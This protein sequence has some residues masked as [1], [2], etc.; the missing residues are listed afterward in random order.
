MARVPTVRAVES[1]YTLQ[2]G[3]KDREKHQVA[4]GGRRKV[5]EMM[6]ETR[7]H[8]IGGDRELGKESL[9]QLD[10]AGWMEEDDRAPVNSKAEMVF[11]VEC[12]EDLRVWGVPE[13]WNKEVGKQTIGGNN[14]SHAL[15]QVMSEGRPRGQVGGSSQGLDGVAE[16]DAT[17]DML[18][19]ENLLQ[20]CG[21]AHNACPR[22]GHDKDMDKK[23]SSELLEVFLSEDERLRKCSFICKLLGGRPNRGMVRDM[24]QVALMDRVP[25]ILN[26]HNMGRNFFHVEV[27]EGGD[28]SRI[29]DM[30]FVELKYG[31][32][33]L[34]EW[35]ANFNAMEEDKKI[36]NP[37]V[38]SMIFPNLPRQLYPLIPKIGDE[39]GFVCPSKATMVDRVRDYPKIRVLVQSSSKLPPIIRVHDVEV[40]L[41]NLAVEYEGLPG[42]CFYC[43]KKGHI[44]KECPR[45]INGNGR[46]GKDKGQVARQENIG[47]KYQNTLNGV[48][49]EKA[50]TYSWTLVLGRK[51][52]L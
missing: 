45:K 17:E 22:G 34:L 44:A 23:E 3:N 6:K 11:T 39:I 20:E 30:K 32:A 10:K 47:V 8:I 29:V 16:L 25:Q 18:Q 2:G 48:V 36:G 41:I 9:N 19:V 27:V 12:S 21:H 38:I 46:V 5:D 37:R 13:V 26:V 43:K 50:N 14:S 42:Q 28:V 33:L 1:R 52:R 31:R 7:Q 51:N 4:N 40:G 24:L 49:K 15:W 35:H